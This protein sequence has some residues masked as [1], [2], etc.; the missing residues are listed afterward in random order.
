MLDM[1]QSKI[2]S[3]KLEAVIESVIFW[4]R[5]FQAP[6]YL[7][8]IIA[9]FVYCYKFV[10]E[11]I[12]MVA[13]VNELTEEIFMLKVLTLVDITM[14][15]NLLIMVIIGGYATFVSR[16]NL[17]GH[18]DKPDW[19]QKVDA[20]TIKVKMAASLVGISGVH[21]L[22][23]FINVSNKPVEEVRLQILIHVVFVLSA[24]FLAITEWVLRKQSLMAA[25][26]KS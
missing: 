16:L 8:L 11:L 17:D 6:M 22:K 26:K 21:L 1:G 19:L 4:G 2:Q 25:E 9:G 5:W 13:K 23:S 14:V 10:I 24:L 12:N 15:A 7:G 3:R 18:E 20:G